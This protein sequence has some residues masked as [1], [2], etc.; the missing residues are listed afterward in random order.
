VKT[1]QGKY[2]LS[3]SWTGSKNFAGKIIGR[4]LWN[5]KNIKNLSV[6][7][8]NVHKEEITVEATS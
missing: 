2:I 5:K 7:D 1:I 4:V 3:F 8:D 6:I